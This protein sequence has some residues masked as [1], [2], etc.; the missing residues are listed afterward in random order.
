MCDSIQDS[1]ECISKEV[2]RNV[3]TSGRTLHPLQYD[4]IP[5]EAAPQRA[6]GDVEGERVPALPEHRRAVER[7]LKQVPLAR[8][9]RRA[10]QTL[11]A[12]DLPARQVA[13]PVPRAVHEDARARAL[14]V[15]READ[16]E[17]RGAVRGDPLE[18]KLDVPRPQRALPE[19]P[20]RGLAPPDGV[21]EVRGAL[22]DEPVLVRRAAVCEPERLAVKVADLEYARAACVQ[23]PLEP[24]EVEVRVGGRAAVLLGGDGDGDVGLEERRRDVCER[25]AVAP[26]LQRIRARADVGELEA[27]ALV[28]VGCVVVRRA[29]VE[30]GL[31]GVVVPEEDGGAGGGAAVGERDAAAD[32]ADAR[33]VGGPDGGVGEPGVGPGGEFA[34]GAPGGVFLRAIVLPVEGREC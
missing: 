21:R 9:R 26:R 28:G 24:A 12:Q 6:R 1:Q 3:G 30:R 33:V 25:A 5:E 31:G 2:R 23:R 18:L 4:A 13:H 11:V 17:Q 22:R 29:L 14:R 10:V 20:V 19:A 34:R 7:E 8:R 15:A 16:R 27:A 32:G